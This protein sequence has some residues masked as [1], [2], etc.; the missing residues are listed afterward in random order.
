MIHSIP[1][2]QFSLA[3]ASITDVGFMGL[4][5]KGLLQVIQS[6]HH[7]LK[8]TH[9]T[10]EANFRSLSDKLITAFLYQPITLQKIIQ[11]LLAKKKKDLETLSLLPTNNNHNRPPSPATHDS[12]PQATAPDIPSGIQSTSVHS[13]R[14]PAP[15]ICHALKCRL[16]RAQG[17]LRRPMMCASNKSMCAG[18]SSES[19]RHRKTLQLELDFLKDMPPNSA[20]APLLVYRTTTVHLQEL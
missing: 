8:C 17:F 19:S 13:P 6:Y 9:P 15:R 20:L 12:R 14:S 4:F 2:D 16:L 18:C 1:E 11:I 3:K 10:T 5:P 7:Q